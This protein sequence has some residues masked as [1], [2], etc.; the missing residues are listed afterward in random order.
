MNVVPRL[1]IQHPRTAGVILNV[2][3]LAAYFIVIIMQGWPESLQS[4]VLATIDARSYDA[5]GR[6]LLGLPSDFTA[7]D[8]LAY[9]PFLFP[10]LLVSL[11]SGGSLLPFWV[12][13]W[14]AWMFA[15]NATW[16][17]LRKATG[18]A[19]ISIA[20]ALALAAHPGLIS[21]SLHGLT[22]VIT[23]SLVAAFLWVWQSDAGSARKLLGMIALA[24]CL[25]VVRP[26]FIIL[27]LF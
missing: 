12:L 8:P 16:L 14:G 10:V 17:A 6:M 3:A 22:E 25:S 19:W 11:T 20:G 13:Q 1:S 4:T 21:L 2:L 15:I 23:V 24:A 27:L 7:Y 9:R 26:V 5:A 18:N